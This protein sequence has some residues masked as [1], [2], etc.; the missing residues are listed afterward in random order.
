MRDTDGALRQTA[1]GLYVPEAQSRVRQVWTKDEARL[2]E[3]ATKLCE[4]HGVR[5][6]LGCT[7]PGC[8]A[9]PI[10]RVRL[11]DGGISL[12]CDHADRLLPRSE[13]H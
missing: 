1:S 8:Q 5:V 2:L 11:A 6:Y 4:G 13:A 9:S 3:R 10:A 7:T 12:Q